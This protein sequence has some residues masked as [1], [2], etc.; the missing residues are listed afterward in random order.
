M[1]D[2]LVWR[3][4]WLSRTI[5][6]VPGCDGQPRRGP[7]DVCSS[8]PLPSARPITY[9]PQAIC[10][11]GVD[12]L[13]GL[14][15]SPRYI[16]CYRGVAPPPRRKY[17]D[18]A[19]WTVL[20]SKC[21]GGW[22]LPRSSGGD[23]SSKLEGLSPILR[24]CLAAFRAPSTSSHLLHDTHPTPFV[25]QRS[26]DPSAIV[27]VGRHTPVE[28]ASPCSSLKREYDRLCCSSSPG[29]ILTPP[30][31]L[32]GHSAETNGN[33]EWG[34]TRANDTKGEGRG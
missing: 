10:T 8:D 30:P 5:G 15:V 17:L 33:Y 2:V 7:R 9:L 31:P 32:P 19:H 29:E 14:G 11:P 25:F 27:V 23:R 20:P 22:L 12:R 13:R 26:E 3:L 1:G 34:T 24:S 28:A 6:I 18:L 4:G 21:D 16:A